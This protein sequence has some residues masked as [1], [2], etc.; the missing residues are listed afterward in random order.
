MADK[1]SQQVLRGH[2]AAAAS[3]IAQQSEN[4]NHLE[5]DKFAVMHA[6]AALFCSAS[7]TKRMRSTS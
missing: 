6:A 2:S 3:G 5:A 7:A 4:L 1:H